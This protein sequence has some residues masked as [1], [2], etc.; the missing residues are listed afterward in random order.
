MLAPDPL[1]LIGLELGTGLD[2]VGIG[3]GGIGKRLSVEV[4]QF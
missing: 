1:S 4:P 3:P 2:W